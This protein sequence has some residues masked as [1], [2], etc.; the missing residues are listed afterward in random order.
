MTAK[1]RGSGAQ[2]SGRGLAVKV[3]TAKRRKTSS[4]RWLQRQLNDP[5]V[6]KAHKEGYRSRA[7]YKL[8][9]LDD[10]FKFLRPGLAV[11]DLGAAP[12]GWTQVIVQRTHSDRPGSK[13]HVVAIDLSAVDPIPGAEVF[14]LD[15]MAD[16]APQIIRERLGRAADVV[17]SDM[18]PYTI[19][20][21]NTDHIRIM[22][23][24]EAAYEFAIEV[25]AP[26][27][28][29]VA[30]V[31]QGGTEGQLL[32][33]MKLA[34]KTVRHAKPP[35]SRTESSEMYVIATGFRGVVEPAH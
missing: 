22:M 34:F 31:F 28:V 20:H 33:R 35:A 21:A 15:F 1:K 23:L 16:D 26:G 6:E 30:K 8:I 32:A 25:L 14:Q 2:G 5:Y 24:A 29:F 18:A 3:K 19:G 10:R 13:S 17:L 7:A 27:G 4:V 11:L 12:G 9:E